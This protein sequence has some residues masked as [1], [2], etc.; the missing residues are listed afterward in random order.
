[1]R[2]KNLTIRKCRLTVNSLPDISCD[3]LPDCQIVQHFV[4]LKHDTN[5]YRLKKRSKDVLS[6]QYIAANIFRKSRNLSTSGRRN[7]KIRVAVISGAP[8]IKAIIENYTT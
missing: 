2:K 7:Y 3:L 5:K 4:D 1:M 8:S 6:V